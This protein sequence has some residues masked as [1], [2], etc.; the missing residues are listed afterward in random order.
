MVFRKKIMM[1]MYM[2]VY[3]LRSLRFRE[4]VTTSYEVKHFRSY[5]A[6]CQGP[7]LHP[8]AMHWRLY[9][10]LLQEYLNEIA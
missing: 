1:Y 5:L 4:L 6:D 3:T 2:C 8:R 7:L 10:D 9:T